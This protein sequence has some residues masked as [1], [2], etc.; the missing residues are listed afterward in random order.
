M[1]NQ[2]TYNNNYG[3]TFVNS[4]DRLQLELLTG[5]IRTIENGSSMEYS[6]LGIDIMYKILQFF[7]P[8]T[9]LKR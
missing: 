1:L 5:R 4:N 6:I 9:M 2:F 8:T 3:F 7:Y